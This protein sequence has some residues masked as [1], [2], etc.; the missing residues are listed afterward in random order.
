MTTLAALISIALNILIHYEVIGLVLLGLVIWG[1]F[2]NDQKTMLANL[3]AFLIATIFLIGIPMG[4][5]KA[6]Y[7]QADVP[8]AQIIEEVRKW[9]G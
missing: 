6:V 1:V 9:I 5:I 2:Q 4:I 7:P 3:V 8:E